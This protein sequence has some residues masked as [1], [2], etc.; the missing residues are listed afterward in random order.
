MHELAIM[1][2]ALSLALDRA[3]KAGA[4]QVH[5][6]R[7][8]IGVL[9]GV[10]PDALQF[11]FEALVPETIAKGA[12]LEI[13]EVPARF[14]C[15]ECRAEFQAADFF[16]QCPVCHVPSGELRSGRELELASLEVD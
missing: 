14:W 9:S 1:D 11:A 16:G 13:E 8:R 15:P 3:A 5:K 4:L 10:V 12:V 7:L 2:S 6:I